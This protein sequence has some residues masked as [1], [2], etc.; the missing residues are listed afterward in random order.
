[1]DTAAHPILF[2]DGHCNLCNGFVQFVI[3][4]DP[5]SRFRF[6]SLQSDYAKKYFSD[7]PEFIQEVSTVLLVENGQLY[8]HS[9]VALQMTKY[10]GA[11]WPTLQVFKVIPKSLRDNIYNWIAKNRYRWFGKS[12]VCMI[13]TPDLKARFLS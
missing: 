13:P 6:A 10:F 1:M 4:R 5:E 3:E 9:D 7:R 12:E 11:L 8:S 2:F